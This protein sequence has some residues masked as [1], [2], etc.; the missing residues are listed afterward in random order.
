MTREKQGE[1]GERERQMFLARESLYPPVADGDANRATDGF[2]AQWG[3]GEGGGGDEKKAAVVLPS[4]PFRVFTGPGW[5]GSRV[6][7]A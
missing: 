2:S 1:E 4:L 3:R 6:Q 7:A 5:Y